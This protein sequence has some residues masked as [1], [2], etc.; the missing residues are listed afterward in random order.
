VVGLDHGG[1][2]GVEIAEAVSID[3]DQGGAD[4]DQLE[5]GLNDHPGETHAANGGPEGLLPEGIGVIWPE[6]QK[7]G[8]TIDQPKLP[9]VTAETPINMM[10]L[11]MHIGGD[12]TR[13]G[14]IAGAGRDGQE[15]ASRNDL[16]E[17]AIQAGATSGRYGASGGI[18][19]DS[20][21]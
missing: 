9:N 20:I 19:L 5:T 7:I 8:V 1:H 15:E 10:V 16:A 17:N 3:A 12:R 18:D 13:N 21:K 14:D 6:R 4:R 11:T 2:Q